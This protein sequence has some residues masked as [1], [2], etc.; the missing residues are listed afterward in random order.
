MNPSRLDSGTEPCLKLAMS[1]EIQNQSDAVDQPVAPNQDASKVACKMPNLFPMYEGN[2][3]PKL[4]ID[5]SDDESSIKTNVRK[6]S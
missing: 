2:D 4:I 1:N 6:R 5:E 3:E